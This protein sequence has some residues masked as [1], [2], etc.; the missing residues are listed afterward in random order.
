M[1]GGDGRDRP[2]TRAAN[3]EIEPLPRDNRH[4]RGDTA[5]GRR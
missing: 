5:A 1:A 3:R 2:T 4:C